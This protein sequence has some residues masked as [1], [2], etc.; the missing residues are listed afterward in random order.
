MTKRIVSISRLNFI[1]ISRS[2]LL[3]FALH[4]VN[5]KAATAI[6]YIN[7]FSRYYG[8]TA[9]RDADLTFPGKPF[10]SSSIIYIYIVPDISISRSD[11]SS[12]HSDDLSKFN[13][14]YRYFSSIFTDFL[15]TTA[16]IEGC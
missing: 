10:T 16:C 12:F 4:F 3:K 5:L 6:N 1:Y 8:G 9:E 15:L 7:N 2:C 11:D 13:F 14:Q